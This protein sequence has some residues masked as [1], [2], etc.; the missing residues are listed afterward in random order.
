MGV[1]RAADLIVAPDRRPASVAGIVLARQRA[2]TA[3]GVVFLSLEDETGMSNVVIWPRVF[4]RYRR[5]AAGAPILLVTGRLE[6]SGLV[7]NVI[8][9][10]IRPLH[11]SDRE[12]RAPS[13]DF[14]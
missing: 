9:S 7:V 10:D 6:R 11:L 13:R 14:H 5:L 2:G 8:A 12:L 1:T 3:S 4:E